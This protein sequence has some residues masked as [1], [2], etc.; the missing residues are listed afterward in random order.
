MNTEE[1]RK[2]DALGLAA[3]VQ[4]GDL[5]ASELLETA[6][7]R[8]EALNPMLNAIVHKLYD[9]ARAAAAVTPRNSPFAGVPFLV[10][11]LGLEIKD[12]PM[13]AGCR[14]YQTFVS[15]EDSFAVRRMRAAGL[16]LFGKTN[17]PEFGLTPYTEPK[18]FGPT[19]NP[20][21]LAYSPGGSSGGSAAS[22]AAGIVP[23]ASA[24]DGGG[25]IRI[26]ASCNGLFGLKPSR[27]RVSWGN[28]F[29]D[30][31]NGAAVEGCISRSVR[32][33][34][35]YLDAVSGGAPGDPYFLP[36]P[37]RSFLE[38]THR[39]PGVLRVGFSTANP[40]GMPV[41]EVCRQAVLQ[42]AA[43]LRQLG[44]EVEEAPLPYREEDLTKSFLV[45][46]AGETAGEVQL[47]RRFLGRKVT[48]ADVENNT[49]A[50]AL[51]GNTFTAGDYAFAKKQWNELSRRAAVFH[52][53][54]DLLLT[55]VQGSRPVQSGALQNSAAEN[56]LI[57]TI[58]ALGLGSAIR[59]SI[60]QL[61]E[62]IFGYIP[63]TPFANMTGQP[64]MSIPTLW[65]A[66]ENLPVGAMFTAPIGQEDVLFRLAGQLEQAAPWFDKKPAL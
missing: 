51:L 6:I 19:K 60:R 17:T 2:H 16:L 59:A 61:A 40:L 50:L 44:H 27:G 54:Y 39:A 48:T 5:P 8:A 26:P 55:P 13:C 4:K 46:I 3:L 9:E 32:D 33:T 10:K 49:F 23:L 14:G 15:T 35:A 34:A 43:L 62:K 58:N 12:A 28:R 22:V 21:N 38:E 11:D 18:L 20:W 64:S 1:Y 7:R 24:N 29:G 66:E 63:W 45:V 36:S 53:K 37:Q 65:T 57:N 30:M 42:M 41:D 56:A 25:S 52:E 47:L 31:W